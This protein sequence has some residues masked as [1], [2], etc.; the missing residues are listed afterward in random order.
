MLTRMRRCLLL[1]IAVVLSL[2]DYNVPSAR[3][4]D[5]IVGGPDGWDEGF[6]Y[7]PL[8]AQEGDVL[9][10]NTSSCTTYTGTGCSKV[11]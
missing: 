7:D 9:V 3:A 6:P 11:H 1:R 4:A 8:Q 2:R 10:R 5:V